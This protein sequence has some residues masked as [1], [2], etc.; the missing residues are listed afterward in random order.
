M[1]APLLLFPFLKGIHT[2][3]VHIPTAFAN[4]SMGLVRGFAAG[5]VAA[6]LGGCWA[7]RGSSGGAGVKN[8]TREVAVKSRARTRVMSWVTRI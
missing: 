1:L 8:Y 2:S 3:T 4:F 6:G 5:I 7:E